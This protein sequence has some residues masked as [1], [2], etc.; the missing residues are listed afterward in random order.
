MYVLVPFRF[1]CFPVSNLS[2]SPTWSVGRSAKTFSTKSQSH[3][4]SS[5]RA[6][7]LNK[8]LDAPRNGETVDGSEIP[9]NHLDFIKPGINYQPQPVRRISEPSTEVLPSLKL[10]ASLHL[11]IDGLEDDPFLFGA[12]PIFRAYISFQE[13]FRVTKSDD[14]YSSIPRFLCV[15]FNTQ[16]LNKWTWWWWHFCVKY[17]EPLWTKTCSQ[18]CLNFLWT[19]GCSCN[20]CRGALISPVFLFTVFIQNSICFYLIH[21]PKFCSA[22]PTSSVLVSH[23]YLQIHQTFAEEKCGQKHT[24]TWDIMRPCSK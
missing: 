16:V 3:I 13:K 17:Y 11:K 1:S 12:R 23:R 22:H 4:V 2:I 18:F 21:S 19:L 5:L 10:T 24:L 6:E 15:S 8:K 7:R 20:P 9:N 14:F